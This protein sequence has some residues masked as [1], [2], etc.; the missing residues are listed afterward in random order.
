MTVT[1]EATMS[2]NA[3]PLG[4]GTSCI[5][6]KHDAITLEFTKSSMSKSKVT[7]G[8]E[9]FG[10]MDDIH[11]TKRHENAPVASVTD[12]TGSNT[13]TKREGISRTVV[14]PAPQPKP[15]P[16]NMRRSV[17]IH[18][19]SIRSLS[20]ISGIEKDTR[21]PS[22]RPMSGAPVL[23]PLLNLNDDLLTLVLSFLRDYA[24]YVALV[25]TRLLYIEQLIRGPMK[26]RFVPLWTAFSG[27]SIFTSFI[28]DPKFPLKGGG[29]RFETFEADRLA[30]RVS[31]AEVMADQLS[32]RGWRTLRL[33]HF[34]EVGVIHY[35]CSRNEK[36]AHDAMFGGKFAEGV[37]ELINA[38]RHEERSLFADEIENSR[39]ILVSVIE[40]GHVR[41]LRH[42]HDV[43]HAEA[44][45]GKLDSESLW[46]RFFDG[47]EALIFN[48][49]S[50]AMSN[51]FGNASEMVDLVAQYMEKYRDARFVKGQL[52][53][54]LAKYA[55]NGIPHGTRCCVLEWCKEKYPTNFARVFAEGGG[56][57]EPAAAQSTLRTSDKDV[58]DFLRREMQSGGWLD[59]FPGVDTF[60]YNFD[61]ECLEA[62]LAILQA[63]TAGEKGCFPAR[64]HESFVHMLVDVLSKAIVQDQKA[65][66]AAA[67][68]LITK[69]LYRIPITD[70]L[71]VYLRIWQR[72]GTRS[73]GVFMDYYKPLLVLYLSACI[74]T[75][76]HAPAAYII[77]TRG[78][79]LYDSVCPEAQKVLTENAHKRHSTHPNDPTVR[80]LLLQ[81][82]VPPPPPP[83]EASD[84]NSRKRPRSLPAVLNWDSIKS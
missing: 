16:Q 74:A 34:V 45:E 39:R 50:K 36:A 82:G 12:W 25:C 11:E 40:E 57:S 6:S 35:I 73:D 66:D 65:A 20:C 59:E 55:I 78:S 62:T 5:G 10:R 81:V 1:K 37:H 60:V 30:I 54:R 79:V 64:M 2:H 3:M 69:K 28:H 18:S 84:N 13:S 8:I 75:G 15:V 80:K 61:I 52:T 58:Y 38:L 41:I 44:R 47:G 77:D 7:F 51:P 29:M 53:A 72:F 33:A 68:R 32:T 48:A 24:G 26:P 14:S 83:P 19:W 27:Y 42:I 49:M 46:A 63:R 23:C 22:G 56:G 17:T 31:C 21:T 4:G 76:R 9:M 70:I 71:E 67:R 43:V